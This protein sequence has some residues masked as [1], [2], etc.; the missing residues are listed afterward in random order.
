VYTHGWHM[1]ALVTCL[2]TCPA[3]ATS[4]TRAVEGERRVDWMQ[5]GGTR[6]V[7][8]LVRTRRVHVLRRVVRRAQTLLPSCLRPS[9]FGGQAAWWLLYDQ[10]STPGAARFIARSGGC[11]RRR[12]RETTR[13]HWRCAASGAILMPPGGYSA[14][15]HA[16][17]QAMPELV[18]CRRRTGNNV[19]SRTP[20]CVGKS[21]VVHHGVRARVHSHTR[22]PFALTV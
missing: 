3:L 13:G 14:M 10:M 19:L 15:Y 22:L 2:A 11:S 12:S 17:F 7:L 20:A 5:V 6:P 21:Q 8:D 4:A 16:V 9:A 1:C 18:P